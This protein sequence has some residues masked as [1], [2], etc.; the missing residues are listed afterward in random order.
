MHRR[1][2]VPDRCS[3]SRPCWGAE[4]GDLV[5]A[6][7]IA[8][9]QPRCGWAL[10]LRVPRVGRRAAGQ[11]WA[12]RR[13]PV[14][15][16]PPIPKRGCCHPTMVAFIEHDRFL[17]EILQGDQV[18]LPAHGGAERA[19]SSTKNRQKIAKNYQDLPRIDHLFTRHGGDC[20][21]LRPPCA[22]R[23]D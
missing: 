23:N 19:A 1:F 13:N 9:T 17:V 20:E 12:L 6:L 2:T 5:S 11:P 3:D 21:S 16:E 18:V 8:A 22:Q 4:S 10:L 15:I 7:Q 14:G